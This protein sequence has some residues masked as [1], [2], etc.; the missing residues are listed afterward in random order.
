MED[1]GELGEWVG[2]MFGRLA[3]ILDLQQVPIAMPSYAWYDSRGDVMRFG[4]GFTA[5]GSTPEGVELGEIPA[6]PAALTTVHHG[7]IWRIAGTWQAVAREADSRG[8]VATG[9]GLEVYHE[10]PEDRPDDWVTEVQLPV[11]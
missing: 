2:P 8:L 5:S 3:E 6:Q 9:P 7:A 10:C 1:A 4:V 11:E